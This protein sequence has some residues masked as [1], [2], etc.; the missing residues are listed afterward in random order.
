[1][2]QLVVLLMVGLVASSCVPITP[3]TRIQK[4]PALYAALSPNERNLVERGE[5]AKGMS[6]DA[7]FLAW[8]APAMSYEGYHQGKASMRWDYTGARAV[9]SERFYGVYGYGGYGGYGYHGHYAHPYSAYAYGFAPELAFVPYR[10]ASVW[11]VN[12]RVDGWERL[13]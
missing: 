13:H 6:R 5:L 7:V 8:G 2:K 11:F 12:N 1:M 4:H 3:Q 10:R 9:Y